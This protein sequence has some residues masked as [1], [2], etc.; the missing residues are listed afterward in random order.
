MVASQTGLCTMVFLILPGENFSEIKNSGLG[1]PPYCGSMIH[2]N[3]KFTWWD[4]I[5][6]G[7]DVAKKSF[8]FSVKM[9]NHASYEEAT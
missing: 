2:L 5:N 4:E 1:L 3:S 8:N 6:Q 9:I 7:S